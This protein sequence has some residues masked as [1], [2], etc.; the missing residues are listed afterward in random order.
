MKQTYPA[1]LMI[2]KNFYIWKWNDHSVTRENP[3]HHVRTYD[4]T[5]RSYTILA[6]DLKKRERPDLY[7]NLIATLFAMAYVD[8]TCPAW[9]DAPQEL[10]QKAE[11]VIRNLL[12]DYGADYTEIPENIRH[13]KYRLMVDYTGRE[14]QT[15]I[16]EN[17]MSWVR[18]FMEQKKILI[19]GYGVVGSNLARELDVLK[20]A[21]YDKYKQIDTREEGYRYRVAFI[22]VDTPYS[23]E[24]PCDVSEVIHA[25]RENDADV[26]VLKST[27][28]PGTTDTLSRG[29]D[30][31]IIFSPE[32]YGGTQ[33][34]NNFDFDFT[35]LGGEKETCLKVIQILQRVYDGRHQF[36]IT[37]AK[38]SRTGKIHGKC[39]PHP[40]Q[41]EPRNHTLY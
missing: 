29:M 41:Q 6:E 37:D 40:Q 23:P 19:V 31:K 10:R 35:I 38:N 4:K 32:Y 3:Y 27:I 20:P 8:V 7:R 17:M 30:K 16:F 26:Y 9:K 18:G 28:L 36:R 13:A 2:D 15:G 24:N 39:L 34:C 14:E 1:L 25:I 33:H 12:R 5:V 21:I 11:R 22:C